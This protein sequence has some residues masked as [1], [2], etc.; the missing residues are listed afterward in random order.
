MTKAKRINTWA[1]KNGFDN[2]ENLLHYLI[3][4]GKTSAEIAKIITE[5]GINVST[6]YISAR[7]NRYSLSVNQKNIDKRPQ[8]KRCGKE[9]IM[10]NHAYFGSRCW[11]EINYIDNSMV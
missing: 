7:R 8:C 9:P 5:S 4:T 3:S 1:I 2:E 10:K 6:Q 11:S